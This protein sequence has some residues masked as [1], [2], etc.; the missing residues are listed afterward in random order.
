[1]MQVSTGW[2]SFTLTSLV[3]GRRAGLCSQTCL[4]GQ[5]QS[6]S[7][8]VSLPVSSV[9]AVLPDCL[10]TVLTTVISLSGL[11]ASL[12]L[13]LLTPHSRHHLGLGLHG[14]EVEPGGAHLHVLNVVA[15]RA[16]SFG[17]GVAVLSVLDQHAVADVL[18]GAVGGEGRHTN[19][20]TPVQVV[21]N[22][23]LRVLVLTLV[24]LVL[25]VELV[26]DEGSRSGI[27]LSRPAMLW[28]WLAPANTGVDPGTAVTGAEVV[29]SL[30]QQIES[31]ED[32]NLNITCQSLPTQS[33]YNTHPWQEHGCYRYSEQQ[34][35]QADI[36]TYIGDL[37]VCTTAV[38]YKG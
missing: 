38:S 2:G 23:P 34:P 16:D 28:S 12:H 14:D 20:S 13:A 25:L 24:S 8:S 3:T 29:L 9:R 4:G 11:T 36:Q 21:H 15:L 5:S 33:H 1:M 17:D 18:L 32:E 19:L 27:V 6:V 31:A 22:T 35:E 10:G 37:L 30:T 7:Q 26:V